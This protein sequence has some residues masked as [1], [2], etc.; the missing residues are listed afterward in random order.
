[1]NRTLTAPLLARLDQRA[2][3][4]SLTLD[5]DV[6]MAPLTTLR[7][8]GSADRIGDRLGIAALELQVSA[9]DDLR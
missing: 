4:A 9:Q 2:A 3:E 7:V 5:H 6:P 1:M 8:G